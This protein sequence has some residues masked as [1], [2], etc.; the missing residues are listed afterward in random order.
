MVSTTQVTKRQYSQLSLH[1]VKAG[2]M[3]SHPCSRGV[4]RNA[5][6]VSHI[7]HC[8]VGVCFAFQWKIIFVKKWSE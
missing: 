1:V 5:H 6:G 7:F 8:D 2:A 3:E 4:V